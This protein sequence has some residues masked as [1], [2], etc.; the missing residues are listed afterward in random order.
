M[1]KI[2]L[3]LLIVAMMAPYV[4][5]ADVK[6]SALPDGGATVATTDTMAGVVG[7]ATSRFTISQLFAIGGIYPATADGGRGVLITD[8]TSSF[9]PTTGNW[10]TFINNIPYFI[11]GATQTRIAGTASPSFTTPT[12]GAAVGTSLFATGRVDGLVGVTVTTSATSIDSTSNKSA[13]YFNNG[14]TA[15]DS[16]FSLPTAAVGLQYCVKNYTGVTKQLR[17]ATSA[18]GQYIDMDGALIPSG[19]Y[20]ISASPDANASGACFVGATTTRWIMY[21]QKGTWTSGG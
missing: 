8:N 19:G 17:I 6:I 10:Y 13:Y 3:G 21:T 5:G 1:K 20:V 7:G 18:A 4:W 2:L 12:L 16:I 15:A 14:A 11:I 9:T